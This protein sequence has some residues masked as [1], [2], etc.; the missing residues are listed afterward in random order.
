MTADQYDEL[1]MSVCNARGLIL[2]GVVVDKERETTY[3]LVVRLGDRTKHHIRIDAF[4]A[5]AE[6]YADA[7]RRAVDRFIDAS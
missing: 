3:L 2:Y 4:D 6:G 5:E 1:F 7:V